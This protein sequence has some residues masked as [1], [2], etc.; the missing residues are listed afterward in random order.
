MRKATILAL[1]SALLGLVLA[2]PANAAHPAAPSI[3]PAQAVTAP[4]VATGDPAAWC[5]SNVAPYYSYQNGNCF[6][7]DELCIM[8]GDPLIPASAA[9]QSWNVQAG[10]EINYANNCVTA[11]YLP[12]RRMTITSYNEADGQCGKFSNQQVD[13]IGRWTNNPVIWINFYYGSC[14]SYNEIGLAHMATSYMG[15]VLGLASTNTV[16]MSSHVMNQTA[17]SI[18]NVPWATIYDGP[19]MCRV[20]AYS[21]NG[22]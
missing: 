15:V 5:T 17:W 7:T 22:C 13:S 1:V 6:W 3:S 10:T 18:R 8:S 16:G 19:V 11:G 21:V 14:G 4:Q 12:S 9:A 2:V 20:G